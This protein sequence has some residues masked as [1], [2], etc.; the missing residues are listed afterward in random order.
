[1]DYVL[2]SLSNAC[3]LGQDYWQAFYYRGHY[4]EEK[5]QRSIASEAGKLKSEAVAAYQ[6]ALGISP[7]ESQVHR[8]LAALL[9]EQGNLPEAVEHYLV[10]LR[11]RQRRPRQ[12]DE[13]SLSALAWL[14]ATTDRSQLPNTTSSVELAAPLRQLQRLQPVELAEWKG[15]DADRA[16]TGHTQAYSPVE[17]AEWACAN[18]DYKDPGCLMVL[19]AAYADAGQFEDAEKAIQRALKSAAGSRLVTQLKQQ[20]ELY[21]THQPYREN[22]QRIPEAIR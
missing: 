18:T 22:P 6:T 12:Y 1:L 15:V 8:A 2:A 7:G 20:V 3:A 17:L 19:G 5:S 9:V 13:R 21:K 10:I 4:L 14:L 16:P 11:V